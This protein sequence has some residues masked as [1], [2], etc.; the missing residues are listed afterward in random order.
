M[1]TK[2]LTIYMVMYLYGF[3]LMIWALYF[4]KHPTKKSLKAAKWGLIGLLLTLVYVV[5]VLSTVGIL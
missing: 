2:T 3:S 4:D 1:D 5:Y